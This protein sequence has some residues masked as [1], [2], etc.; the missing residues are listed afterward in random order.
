[1][2]R[3]FENRDELELSLKLKDMSEGTYQIKVYRINEKNGSVISIWGE[4]DYEKGLSRNDIKYFRRVCEPKL[5]IQKMKMEQ[6]E[7]NLN[8]K[9]IANEIAFIRIRKIS[10]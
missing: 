9:L 4:L 3:Y 7:M 5:T 8:I 10:E 1:M 6:N 2:W